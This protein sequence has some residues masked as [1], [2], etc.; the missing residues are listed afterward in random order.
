MCQPGVSEKLNIRDPHQ[1]HGTY[2]KAV[3]SSVVDRT[4]TKAS[5][6]FLCFRL[7]QTF[8]LDI[9]QFLCGVLPAGYQQCSGTAAALKLIVLCLVG[10]SIVMRAYLFK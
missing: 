5:Q 1:H 6:S 2:V 9:L 4:A 7:R 10:M 3:V 8:S